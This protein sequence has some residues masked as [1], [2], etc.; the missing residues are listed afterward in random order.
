M[1]VYKRNK[2]HQLKFP[3][4][5]WQQLEIKFGYAPDLG[6]HQFFTSENNTFIFGGCVDGELSAK[7]HMFNDLAQEIERIMDMDKPK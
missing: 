3:E 6:G 2:L 7:C 1:I 4:L 5:D